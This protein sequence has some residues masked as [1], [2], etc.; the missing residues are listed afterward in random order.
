[1]N[2]FI[3]YSAS[4]DQVIA[5]RLQTLASVY[6]F[7]AYVPPAFTRA[8]NDGTLSSTVQQELKAADVVFAV[9]NQA[10]SPSTAAELN[11]ALLLKKLVVPIVGR[12]V[13]Q[14]FLQSFPKH[15]ILD[16]FKPSNIESDIVSF[17]QKSKADKETK[18]AVIGLAALV[19]GMLLLS[20]AKD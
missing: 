2:V 9:I 4:D 19:I 20:S 5:L 18:A 10:P 13:D 15:F 1:M 8:G 12:W 17:L 7:R 11:Y 3:S 6:G 14:R 16:P